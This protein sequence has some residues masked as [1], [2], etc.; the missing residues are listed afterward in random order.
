[1]GNGYNYGNYKNPALDKLVEQAQR[2]TG[3][4]RRCTLYKQAQRVLARDYVS[5]N[6]SLPQYTT[7]LRSNVKGYAYNP[8]HHQTENTY[9]ISVGS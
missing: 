7:V 8:A 6:V 3:Q 2:V 9:D 4:A 1:V 5:M